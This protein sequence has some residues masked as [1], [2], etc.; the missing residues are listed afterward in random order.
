MPDPRFHT[1]SDPKTLGE[2]AALIGATF[3]DGGDK[4]HVISDVA[5]LNEAQKS[6]ISFLDNAK[7]KK[8]FEQ[9]NAGACIIS[10]QMAAFAPKNCRLRSINCWRFSFSSY[11]ISIA[12]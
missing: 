9:T 12:S 11:L 1:V 10:E 8:D 4:D 2:L 7:Y 5:P 3:H 6:D